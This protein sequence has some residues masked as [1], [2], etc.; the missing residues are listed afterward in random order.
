MNNKL[1]N[2]KVQYQKL[3]DQLSKCKRK[4]IKKSKN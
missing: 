3:K 2:L 4:K 1:K